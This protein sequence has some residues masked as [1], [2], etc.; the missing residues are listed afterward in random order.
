[1]PLLAV[2]VLTGAAA[3]VASGG[4]EPARAA[5]EASRI[6]LDFAHTR[7]S[8]R[9]ARAVAAHG[10]RGARE[11]AIAVDLSTGRTVYSLHGAR[12]LEPASNE[13]LPLTFA[14]LV[15]LG[16][17]FRWHTDVL[18]SGRRDG[19]LWRGNLFLQGHGDPTLRTPALIRLARTLH[20]EG[21]RRVTGRVFGDESWFDRRR[22]AP[23]WKPSFYLD[24][25]PPL[26]ALVVDR[27][28]YAGEI[29][30][31]PAGAAAAIFTRVLDRHGV[32][33]AHGSARGAAPRRAR[34]LARV[35]SQ[36]LG[37]V[38]RFMDR[39][40]DNF[41]AEMLLKTLGA[42]LADHGTTAAGARVVRRTLVRAHVPLA[43]VRL[44]DGSGLSELDRLTVRSLAAILVAA[45]HTRRV[46]GPLFDA[47]AVSGRKGTLRY[48]LPCGPAYGVVHG[49]TG[50]TD[51][52]SALSG[53]VR[54]RFA[55][56]VLQNGSPVA[57]TWA[58][59]A[60]DRFAT[61]LA[62]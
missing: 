55:F 2:V 41:T 5:H 25:S 21:I 58:H 34:L 56:A 10:A 49:K 1:V 6:R 47:L 46:G 39:W 52:A 30:T 43:G 60:Q 19:P 23:G 31:D 17:G 12:P 51:E 11:A 50:T 33:V 28:V 9:L 38:L 48:R 24:E 35:R 61:A 40:S 15:R 16:V 57:V 36:R 8:R 27:A 42:R 29:S 59:R 22:T 37:A 7:L 14:A 45:S 32:G 53:Y 18:G 13:K 26:S 20:G 54:R 3:M 62:A 44:V 4:R